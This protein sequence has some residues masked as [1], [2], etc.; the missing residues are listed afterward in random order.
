MIYADAHAGRNGLREVWSPMPGD[1]CC[2]NLHG[3]PFAHTSFF[4]RWIDQAAGTFSDVGGN[5]GPTDISNGG[6]VMRQTRNK[7]MVSH[8]VRVG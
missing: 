2:F 7:G 4:E 3:D 1:I 6:A 5:T 8:F